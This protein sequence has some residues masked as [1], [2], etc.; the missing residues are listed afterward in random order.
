MDVTIPLI[1]FAREAHDSFE[2]LID[3]GF[4]VLSVDWGRK[5][6]KVREITKRAKQSF[7]GNKNEQEVTLQGNFDPW[8]LFGNEQFIKENVNKM[9]DGFEI[10]EYDKKGLIVNLGHGMLPNHD[11]QSVEHLIKAVREY[12]KQH[13]KE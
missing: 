1:L 10:K 7:Q 6:R 8:K 13:F 4:N 9:L 12:E 2:E 3:I 5:Q 11:P